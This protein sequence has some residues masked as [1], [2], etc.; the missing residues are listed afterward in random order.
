MR[1]FIIPELVQ[2]ALDI[3]QFKICVFTDA[4]FHFRSFSERENR[5]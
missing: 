4:A 1:A 5:K 3:I 2:I